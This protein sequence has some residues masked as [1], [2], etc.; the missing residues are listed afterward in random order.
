MIT[1][2]LACLA[3]GGNVVSYYPKPALFL[4]EVISHSLGITEWRH[5]RRGLRETVF[6]VARSYTIKVQPSDV[7]HKA[8]ERSSKS[9]TSFTHT[10]NNIPTREL[11]HSSSPA[12][13]SS[14]VMVEM[15]TSATSSGVAMSDTLQTKTLKT[16]STTSDWLDT[17][18]EDWTDVPSVSEVTQAQTQQPQPLPPLPEGAKRAVNTPVFNDE[19][20]ELLISYFP[21]FGHVK[22]ATSLCALVLPKL[23]EYIGS[24]KWETKPLFHQKV[25]S[26]FVVFEPKIVVKEFF[27][28][29]Y[30][31][32]QGRA[33]K[34]LTKYCE[35]LERNFSDPDL[36]ALIFDWERLLHCPK[37]HAMLQDALPTIVE[38]PVDS[39]G[40][41]PTSS[42][43]DFSSPVESSA[44]F[45]DEAEMSQSRKHHQHFESTLNSAG[46]NRKE[47]D[48]VK[49]ATAAFAASLD[50]KLPIGEHLAVLSHRKFR[51]VIA[52]PASLAAGTWKLNGFTQPVVHSPRDG[53]SFNADGVPN[54][55]PVLINAYRMANTT[56]Q[57]RLVRPDNIPTPEIN[58]EGLCN[59]VFV[60]IA[61]LDDDDVSMT[62]WNTMNADQF[63][64]FQ[65]P[66]YFGQTPGAICSLSIKANNLTP[67]LNV[68]GGLFLYRQDCPQSTQFLN[69]GTNFGAAPPFV[70][71]GPYSAGEYEI[72]PPIPL[73]RSAHDVM[74]QSV[75]T[76]TKQGCLFT[77]PM[78]WSTLNERISLT[79]QGKVC[80]FSPL[81]QT[82]GGSAISTSTDTY[83]FMS[84]PS[85]KVQSVLSR[86]T[87]TSAWHDQSYA[88]TQRLSDVRCGVTIEG[89]QEEA[90]WE[91]VV[92]V[93]AVLMPT[94]A[95]NPDWMSVASVQ[96]PYD[97]ETLAMMQKYSYMTP[98]YSPACANGFGSFLSSIGHTISKGVSFARPIL[99][100][101]DQMPGPVGRI[102]QKVSKGLDAVDHVRHISGLQSRQPD[103]RRGNRKERREETREVERVRQPIQ[104]GKHLSGRSQTGRV[105]Q[106]GGRRITNARVIHEPDGSE[107]IEVPR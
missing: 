38:D 70:E 34:D 92:S 61:S 40:N 99:A 47:K 28:C 18:S 63:T 104:N 86:P 58:S 12:S 54:T 97:P 66:G 51:Q 65:T 89:Q 20:K 56:T 8:G 71:Y 106:G 5:H 11:G 30:W 73:S 29:H 53:V 93:V 32:Q 79:K 81:L 16:P 17:S 103:S 88:F 80:Y 87:V 37:I 26:N 94:L 105:A 68:G 85:P 57:G 98:L 67:L 31:K 7:Y 90:V 10:S 15:P 82:S 101:A 25:G 74:F 13:E 2:K 78:N 83:A 14:T 49:L 72:V 95:E 45:L 4:Y 35:Y 69:S 55:D 36:I 107:F 84:I 77:V 59:A 42:G 9:L 27:M 1:F 96:D 62:Q 60:V 48:L 22:H 23:H 102:A 75:A 41:D 44:P 43:G 39:L 19:D 46:F 76:D 24:I 21:K 100:I 64:F 33:T 50:V 3:S 91:F 52:K 6:T